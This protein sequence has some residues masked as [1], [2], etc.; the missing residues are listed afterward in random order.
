[1]VGAECGHNRRMARTSRV[2][3]ALCLAAATA[4]LAACG[5][6]ESGKSTPASAPATA[7]G[8]TVGAEPTAGLVGPAALVEDGVESIIG[9]EQPISPDEAGPTDAQKNGVA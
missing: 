8:G 7:P 6:G 3:V 2:A 5:G 4:V 1:M 9:K